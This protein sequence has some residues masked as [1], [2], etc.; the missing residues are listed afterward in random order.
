MFADHP[1]TDPGDGRTEKICTVPSCDRKATRRGLCGT[2]YGRLKRVGDVQA[3]VPIKVAVPHPP[4]CKVAG[5]SRKYHCQGVCEIHYNRYRRTGLYEIAQT[6]KFVHRLSRVRPELK[7]ADCLECGAD[8]PLTL[9]GE[10]RKGYLRWRCFYTSNKPFGYR[11]TKK[12]H[13]ENP[14]CAWTGPYPP[15]VLDVDHID[16]NHM[17][18]EPSNL[19][20][21][22]SNCHRIKTKQERR[23]P[24]A[25]PRV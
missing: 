2:H 7:V 22:C 8:V 6:K 14:L 9:N 11:A 3:D 17:N 18:D 21:L 20:T 13:C 4:T 16:G 23:N 1:H 5:C 19:M 12:S 15:E 24:H 10:T 25:K